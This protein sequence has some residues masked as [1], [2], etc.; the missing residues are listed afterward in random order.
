MVLRD[1]DHAR[2]LLIYIVVVILVAL[3]FVA[4]VFNTAS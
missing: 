2:Q 1:P 4:Y 3:A